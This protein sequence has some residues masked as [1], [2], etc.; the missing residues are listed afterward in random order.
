MLDTTGSLDSFEVLRIV[1]DE[2]GGFVWSLG[3]A[4]DQI[5]EELVLFGAELL[6]DVGQQVADGLGFGLAGNDECVVLDGSVG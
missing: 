2:E 5:L 1:F 6:D 4:G 3:Q